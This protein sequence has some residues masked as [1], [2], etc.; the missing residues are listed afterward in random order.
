MRNPQARRRTGFRVPAGG[1]G[2][3]GRHPADTDLA[4]AVD[5][6]VDLPERGPAP[7]RDRYTPDCG[8]G[9]PGSRLWRARAAPAL[10]NPSFDD[11]FRI[12]EYQRPYRWQPEQAQ[13]LLADLE[14][15]LLRGDREP[16]FLGSLVLVKDSRT[17]GTRTCGPLPWPRLVESG[18]GL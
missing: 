2:A 7:L 15:A 16:C 17:A 11:D 5:R 4:V 9:L 6:R 8:E 18:G 13:Q 10:A 12:P 14:V 1:G 3:D